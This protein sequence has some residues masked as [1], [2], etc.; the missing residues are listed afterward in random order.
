MIRKVR[1]F[2][3]WML[4]AV[5]GLGSALVA[6][7]AAVSMANPVVQTDAG[8]SRIALVRQFGPLDGASSIVTADGDSWFALAWQR[9]SSKKPIVVD[10]WRRESGLWALDGSVSVGGGY[11]TFPVG[12]AM[13]IK[14]RSIAVAGLPRPTFEI[15]IAGT[16][17]LAYDDSYAI[18][19]DDHGWHDIPFSTNAGPQVSQTITTVNGGRIGTNTNYESPAETDKWYRFVGGDLIATS[20]PGPPPNCSASVLADATTP[21]DGATAVVKQFVCKH[22]WALASGT[23]H[24]GSWIGLFQRAGSKWIPIPIGNGLALDSQFTIGGNLSGYTTSP[25][26]ISVG[27]LL[28]MSQKLSPAIKPLIGS[29]YLLSTS[30]PSICEPGCGWSPVVEQHGALWMATATEAGD[31]GISVHIYQWGDGKWTVRAVISGLNGGSAGGFGTL[32]AVDVTGSTDPDFALMTEGADTQWFSLI[33]DIG[34]TWHAVPFD[35]GSGLTTAIDAAGVKGALVHTEANTCGCADGVETY[36]WERFVNGTFQPTSPP[37]RPAVCP[38][39]TFQRMVDPGETDG[40]AIA[41]VKCEDG[42]AIARITEL[43]LSQAAAAVFTWKDSHWQ[44]LFLSDGSA[45]SV[46]T[47]LYDFPTSLLV[48]LEREVGL[49]G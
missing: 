43:G 3:P 40:F 32:T 33:S 14:V 46:Q 9:P 28:Q 45:L 38:S 15:R 27:L 2:V 24:N 25:Q 20:Q 44:L 4:L 23:L 17:N 29:V 16:D 35:Y 18:V 30:I 11:E 36:L 47:E 26:V 42:W 37:G 49:S 48:S 8:P 39:E 13:S 10:L 12:I 6:V 21:P 5:L 31:G 7:A 19:S 41:A 22:G 34:G 1:R